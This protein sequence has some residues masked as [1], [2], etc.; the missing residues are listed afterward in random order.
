MAPITH[1][2]PYRNLKNS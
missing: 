1:K 2:A